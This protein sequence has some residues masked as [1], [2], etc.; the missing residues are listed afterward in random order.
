MNEHQRAILQLKENVVQWEKR[1]ELGLS[2]RKMY[3]N[4]P[5]FTLFPLKKLLSSFIQASRSTFL[6]S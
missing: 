5:E 4:V 2:C 3:R 1:D 6:Y